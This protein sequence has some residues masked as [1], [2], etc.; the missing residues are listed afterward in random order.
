MKFA[1]FFLGLVTGTIG[2]YA[3]LTRVWWPDVRLPASQEVRVVATAPPAPD[4]PVESEGRGS[5]STPEASS[6]IPEAFASPQASEATPSALSPD[7]ATSPPP[8]PPF[9]MSI[10]LPVLSTD[11][12]RL[13]ARSLV[14]PVSGVAAK[15]LR[16]SFADDRGGRRHDAIDI[17]APRGTPVVAV[18]DG[19]VE[20]LFTSKAGGLTIYQFDSMGEYCYYYAHLDA[21]AEGLAQGAVLRKGDVIGYVG[22]SG[23]ASPEAPHLHFTIFRLGPQKHWW[24]GTAINPYPLWEARPTP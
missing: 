16:D 12:D 2:T 5:A 11:L 6:D 8:T 1:A 7:V 23:N 18:A 19:R 4:A 9:V 13:R 15:S 24:E 10:T 3:F 22:S 14:I 21:Y 17:L 20:K